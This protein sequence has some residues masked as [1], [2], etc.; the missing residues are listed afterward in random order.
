MDSHEF[1]FD[2]LPGTTFTVVLN[3][4]MLK[5]LTDEMVVGSMRFMRIE[6]E[7]D[8]VFVETTPLPEG[9]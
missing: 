9:S 6:P 1:T 3:G 7:P 5:I 8:P 2:S 4:E